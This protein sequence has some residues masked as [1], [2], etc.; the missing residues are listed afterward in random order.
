MTSGGEVGQFRH[1]KSVTDA[2]TF[3]L[4]EALTGTPS[5]DETFELS[6]K[7]YID[8]NRDEDLVEP[9]PSPYHQNPI[10]NLN[11]LV[12]MPGAF[13]LAFK[14]RTLYASEQ[15]LVYSFPA[16]YELTFDSNIKALSVAGNECIVLT[17][18]KQYLVTGNTPDALVSSRLMINQTCETSN[19]G[20]SVVGH[21]TMYPSPDG[22]VSV[23]G[24]QAELITEPLIQ[25]RD[26]A[27]YNPDTFVAE[28]YNKKLFAKSSNVFFV[29][30]FDEGMKTLTTMNY[31]VVGLHYDSIDDIL[32]AIVGTNID[33]IWKSKEYWTV[34]PWRPAV[35]RVEADN[36]AASPNN[37]VLRLYAEDNEVLS[38]DILSDKAIKIPL[39]RKEQKWSFQVESQAEIYD[40][41]ISTSIGE[42]Q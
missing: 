29:M 27:N 40:I 13:A 35:V 32:Y 37:I 2:N 25:P 31:S 11:G 17:D 34:R 9:F 15:D 6:W 39:L 21:R 4:D 10:D 14:D 33:L 22:Y 7:Y 23:Y 1:V 38:V 8:W 41:Q 3:V 24:G 19:R 18:D 28:T 16:A 42:L 12:M 5:A 20:V 30:D 36:Y 26:W